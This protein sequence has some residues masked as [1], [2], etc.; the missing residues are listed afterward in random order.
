M[1]QC[2]A[3]SIGARPVR[4]Q[5]RRNGPVTLPASPLQRWPAIPPSRS[6]RRG[7]SR[8]RIER[9][10]QHRDRDF[11]TGTLHVDGKTSALGSELKVHDD[12]PLWDGST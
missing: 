4:S 2:A 9:H 12:G 7:G 5:C 3:A 6:T 8:D 11:G 1:R 10:R